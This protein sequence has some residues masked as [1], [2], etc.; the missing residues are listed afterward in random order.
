MKKLLSLGV[1]LVFGATLIAGE[2][3]SGLECGAT[4]DAFNVKDITGPFEGT[5]L[6]YRCRLGG[7]PV[8]A[9]FTRTLSDELA[10]LV[11]EVDSV[12]EKNKDKQAGAFIV[13]LS[14]DPDS[15]ESKVKE[16]AK[17]HNLKTPLTVFDGEAGPPS[18]KIAKD[19]EI[20]VNLWNKQK[21]EANHA[22]GKGGLNKDAVAKIVADA[23]KMLK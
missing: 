18:Y 6:C 19:A 8:T 7:R 14:K 20:T 4:P 15:E 17:K 2:V 9:V 13:L 5:S 11:K 1:A 10:S 16:F 12:V 23:E 3:K 21:V 22:F